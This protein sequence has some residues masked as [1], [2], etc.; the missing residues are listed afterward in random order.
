MCINDKWVAGFDNAHKPAPYVGDID[1]VFNEEM[2]T[3]I[4]MVFYQLERFGPDCWYR[5]DMFAILPDPSADELVEE[6]TI[7]EPVN[8]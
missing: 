2:D 4:G 6:T 5:S 1:V 7:A 8:H 3:E